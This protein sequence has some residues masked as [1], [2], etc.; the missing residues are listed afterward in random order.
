MQSLACQK[1]VPC[2]SCGALSIWPVLRQLLLHHT[3][4]VHSRTGNLRSPESNFEIPHQNS[5]THQS[6]YLITSYPVPN[7][8]KGHWHGLLLC[9]QQ[10]CQKH[11]FWFIF[12]NKK[13]QTSNSTGLAP[14]WPHTSYSWVTCLPWSLVQGP[15][16]LAGSPSCS[17]RRLAGK[18]LYN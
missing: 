18:E 14:S 8:G 16:W 9:S 2:I 10:V 5:T 11:K 13:L 1:G 6:W 4:H 12:K 15:S 17:R 3:P 7:S